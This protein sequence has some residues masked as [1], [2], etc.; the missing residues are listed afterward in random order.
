MRKL[1]LSLLKSLVTLIIGFSPVSAFAQ[2]QIFIDYRSE[3]KGESETPSSISA[4]TKSLVI[5]QAIKNTDKPCFGK[6]EPEVIDYASGSFTAPKLK[7]TAYLVD[8]GDSCHPRYMGSMRLAVFSGNN[9]VT[10]GDVTGYQRITKIS[11]INSDG[12]NELTL[13][14]SWMG[15]GY[16]S[17][18]A[19]VVEMKKGGMLTLKDLGEVFGDNPGNFNTIQYQI[20]AVVSTNKTKQGKIA[21]SRA[22]YVARCFEDRGEAIDTKCGT[23]KYISSGEP[24]SS[25]SI[26][27]FLKKTR[28]QDI[29]AD[30]IPTYNA[31]S[32]SSSSEENSPL[33]SKFQYLGYGEHGQAFYLQKDT[34]KDI[35]SG[36]I[37][38]TTT[39]R[40]PEPQGSEQVLFVD[41]EHR[42]N[43]TSRYVGNYSI[44]TFN[45]ND[46]IVEEIKPSVIEYI[47]ADSSILDKGILNAA[48]N[49]Y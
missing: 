25:D 1:P 39:V 17:V 35:G 40:L 11:D 33:D 43:C 8:L 48:C 38:F 41:I 27:K 37:S 2:N 6:L 21:F 16:L 22:N 20:A 19:K 23:Y 15:Q 26:E 18:Y 3:F 29:E 34:V 45:S 12:T 14:G 47:P 24:P 13:Q 49:T 4:K 30:S 5:S 42:A 46:E 31:S 28:S 36:W 44:T 7:Q 10:Y 32:S 9:L